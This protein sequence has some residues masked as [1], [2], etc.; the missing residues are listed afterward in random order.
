[1]MGRMD[2]REIEGEDLSVIFARRHGEGTICIV[3]REKNG[4]APERSIV[5]CDADAHELMEDLSELLEIE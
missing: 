4:F 1:M 2:E 5:L 3:I